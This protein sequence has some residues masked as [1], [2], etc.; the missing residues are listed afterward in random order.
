MGEEPQAGRNAL[1][2]APGRRHN[3]DSNHPHPTGNPTLG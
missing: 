2:L 1:S 3:A